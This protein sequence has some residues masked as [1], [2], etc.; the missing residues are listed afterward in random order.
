[1][2]SAARNCAVLAQR[3]LFVLNTQPMKLLHVAAL[4]VLTAAAQAR[5]LDL[6]AERSSPYDLAVTGTL[7]GYPKGSIV[8]AHWKDLRALP[9]SQL[10]LTGEFTKGPEVVTIVFLADLWKALPASDKADTL[11]ARCASD[12]YAAVY[13]TDFIEKYRPFLVVEIDGKGPK[14][15][16]P[17]GLA[18]NPGPYVITV[19]AALVPEA[20]HFLDLEHKKPWSVTSIELGNFADRFKGITSGKW[21]SLSPEATRGREIWVNSCASCHAGPEGTFGGLKADRPFPIIAAYAHFDR[22]FFT[23]YVRDPKSLVAS[24]KMEAHPWYTD[25]QLEDLVAFITAGQD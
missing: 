17:P 1:M 23:K 12:G 6:H 14:D 3:A 5:A 11:F 18:F 16:P 4:W 13:T 15:W 22:P 25:E 24:A 7:A 9:T 10:T 20:S 2:P 19:S 8:Y 21:A